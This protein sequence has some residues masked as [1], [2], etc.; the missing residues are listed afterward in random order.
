MVESA[1]VYARTCGFIYVFIFVAGLFGEVFVDGRLV[2]EGDAAATAAK[3]VGS[4]Q[5]WRAGTFAQSVTLLCDVA[6]AWLLYILLAPVNRNLALLAALFRLVY[7]PV[8]AFA[9]IA[10][11]AALPLAQN[12]LPEAAAFALR[13]HNAAWAISLLFFGMN[14][15]LAGY[16]IARAPIRVQWLGIALEIAGIC[17]VVNTCMI[18]MAPKVHALFFPWILLPPFFGELSL[19]VWLLVT[20]RFNAIKENER[21]VSVSPTLRS[22]LEKI[23]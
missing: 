5:L 3:I 1:R 2:V 6:V 9:V 17:Y 12:H 22:N 11:Y 18:L 10:H 21:G 23:T 20:N 8:Y 14:L 13:E 7:V 15:F 16:L 4:E 19:C